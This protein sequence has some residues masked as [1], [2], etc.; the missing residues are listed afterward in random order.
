M[1]QCATS[2][3]EPFF[4][5]QKFCNRS[6]ERF[7]LYSF[8]IRTLLLTRDLVKQASQTTTLACFG[9][10]M[11]YEQ[12]N[13]TIA[14]PSLRQLAFDV[15]GDRMLKILP[16]LLSEK[17]QI[18]D[19]SF[20]SYHDRSQQV[21]FF[22]SL[23]QLLEFPSILGAKCPNITELV[24]RNMPDEFPKQAR[25]LKGLMLATPKVK[26]LHLLPP[27][28]SSGLYPGV[29]TTS[30]AVHVGLEALS[31]VF[32]DNSSEAIAQLRAQPRASFPCLR[33]LCIRSLGRT[34]VVTALSACAMSPL[35]NLRVEIGEYSYSHRPYNRGSFDMKNDVDGSFQSR[36]L[37]VTTAICSLSSIHL[38][39][40]SL[41]V[42]HPRL[43]ATARISKLSNVVSFGDNMK[44]LLQH[45]HHISKFCL[46]LHFRATFAEGLLLDIRDEDFSLVPR[47]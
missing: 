20:F 47:A 35:Q 8:H 37:E 18:L 30:S 10:I 16:D 13:L 2:K 26:A 28:S 25:L 1:F 34:A 36:L 21:K 39:E 15:K 9:A 41:E 11:D 19:I 14:F 45:F 5:A 38:D 40:L 29:F 43:G 12:R 46:T 42:H 31:V 32:C 27:W 23:D 24:V 17:L 6:W 22:P 4:I 33:S 44:P 7:Q 3:P